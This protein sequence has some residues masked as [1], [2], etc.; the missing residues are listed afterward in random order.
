MA[1]PILDRYKQPLSRRSPMPA[2]AHILPS[3]QDLG[4]FCYHPTTQSANPIREHEAS[5]FQAQK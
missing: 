1:F 2:N 5:L 3:W 4:T